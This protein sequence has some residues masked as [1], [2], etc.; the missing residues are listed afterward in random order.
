MGLGSNSTPSQNPLYPSSTGLPYTQPSSYFRSTS[1]QPKLEPSP[2]SSGAPFMPFQYTPNQPAGP[3]VNYPPNMGGLQ[4]DPA[5]LQRYA[6]FQMQQNHQRQQRLLLERQREQLAMMGVQVGGEAERR[7]MD[8][9]F[10]VGGGSGSGSNRGSMSAQGGTNGAGWQEGSTSAIQ[11]TSTSAPA[12]TQTEEFVWPTFSTTSHQQPPSSSNPNFAPVPQ[13]QNSHS[14]INSYS[15]PS[16]PS[17]SPEVQHTHGYR[18][19][20]YDLSTAGRQTTPAST[21]GGTPWYAGLSGDGGQGQDEMQFG[22]HGNE[23]EH[24]QGRKRGVDG[25]ENGAGVGDKRIRVV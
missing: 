21:V 11:Q 23:Y 18:S 2:P 10:G 14:H 12:A 13:R 15:I 5:L 22:E 4:W 9:I 17:V 25:L 16:N 19:D 3:P 20:D 7:L 6:E 1:I 24:H 8:D